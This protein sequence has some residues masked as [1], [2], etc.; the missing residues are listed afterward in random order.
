MSNKLTNDILRLWKEDGERIIPQNFELFHSL[1]TQAKSW[2]QKGNYEVAAAHGEIAARYAQYNHGGFFT[3]PELEQILLEIGRKAIPKSLFSH[4]NYSLILDGKPKQILHITT[5]VSVFSGIPRLMRRWIEQ[6]DKNYHSVALTKQSPD[7]VPKNLREAVLNRQ[8]KIYVL[9]E[10]NHTIINRAKALRECATGADIIVLHAWEH[11]VVPIIALAYKDKLT[12]IIYTN[13]GDHC[14]WLGTS[15]IDVVANLRESGMNL[16]KERRGIET[17]RNMLLPTILE[18]LH[19]QLSRADA[20]QQLGIDPTTIVLLSIARADK[21]RTIDG[22]NFAEF[23]LPLLKQHEQ[24]MLII[25]GAGNNSDE[26]W[27]AAIQQTQG[28]IR[29]L[30]QTEETAV[31][32]QAADIYVDSFPFVSNTSLLEAG[33]FG[34]PL[35]SRFPYP[36][37]V[38]GIFG[39]D[40]PGLSGNLIRVTDLESYTAILS[41]LIEDEEHRLSLGEKTREKIANTHWGNGWKCYLNDIYCNAMNTSRSVTNPVL[42]DEMFLD[43]PD[44][45]LPVIHKSHMEYGKML[46]PYLPAMPTL[47]R[48]HFWIRFLKQYGLKNN[49][50]NLLLPEW[51]R[52]RYYSFRWWNN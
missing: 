49:P 38:C 16:S 31:F 2:L 34:N 25:I 51:F 11:D 17:M 47:Y 3:S 37:D 26:D 27:I 42:L 12:P 46:Q 40:M 13:H 48:L 4:K 9:N 1:V 19:R 36:S 52:S 15:I 18:P 20:K 8:G 44:V 39:A 50:I 33:S 5:N 43:E 14:F 45:Y 29:V 21:Y 41:R 35:V 24:A 30:R 22:V 23:H 7:K 32:Y 6:D 28:R 10:K